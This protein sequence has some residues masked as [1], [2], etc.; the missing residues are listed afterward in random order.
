MSA[1][2]HKEIL[3]WLS[4]LNFAVTQND[5]FGRRLAGTGNWI[6]GHDM[7]QE[8]LKTKKILWC[9]GIRK[10]VQNYGKALGTYSKIAGAGKTI[11]AWVFP[12]DKSIWS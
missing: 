9:P 3:A 12:P 8:W 7:Y 6:L 10:Y 2:Q 11:L 1:Q 4:P 5:I